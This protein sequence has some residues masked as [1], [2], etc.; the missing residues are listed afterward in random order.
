MAEEIPEG[1]SFIKPSA[2]QAHGVFPENKKP[3]RDLHRTGA[4]ARLPGW[5][6]VLALRVV[7]FLRVDVLGSVVLALFQNGLVAGGELSA[8][9]FFHAGLFLIDAFLLAFEPCR[10]ASG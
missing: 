3:R 1:L 9:C 2:A 8:V 6:T 4:S 7:V 10:F 5:G